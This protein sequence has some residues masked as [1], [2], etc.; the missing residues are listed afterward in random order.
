[1]KYLWRMSISGNNI[2][3]KYT[4]WTPKKQK[5]SFNNLDF[6]TDKSYSSNDE[7]IK[8]IVDGTFYL[9]QKL[10]INIQDEKTI[11]IVKGFQK[12]IMSTEKPLFS[13]ISDD[14][15]IKVS[16]EN[17]TAFTRE[18]YLTIF[19]FAYMLIKYGWL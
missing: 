16:T 11:E 10:K 15:E 9:C 5:E 6:Y 19:D 4:D 18:Q 3:F 2:V 1:M 14:V 7:A 12:T 17:G 8:P 13:I